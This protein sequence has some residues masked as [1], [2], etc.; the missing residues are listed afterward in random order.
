[1]DFFALLEL[2]RPWLGCFDYDHYIENFARFEREA[3][4]FFDALGGTDGEETVKALL[5]QTEARWAALP[6]ARRAALAGQDRQVLA[7]F[8][9]PAAERHSEAAYAF[10]ELLRARWNAR[11]P[12]ERY[13]AGHYESIVK[14][15]DTD[16]FGVTLRKSSKKDRR[17]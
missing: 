15:F 9:T 6:R 11:F 4:P 3:A 7:L 17:A 8:F 10:A 1:M 5:A 16:F 14:G 2:A 12:R 13:L